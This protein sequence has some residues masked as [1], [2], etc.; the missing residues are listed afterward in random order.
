[1]TGELIEVPLPDC[2][3]D[4]SG[5]EVPAPLMDRGTYAVDP[6]PFGPPIVP[7][8]PELLRLHGFE[9]AS[10]PS[11]VGLPPGGIHISDGPRQTVVVNPEDTQGL[12]LTTNERRLQGCCN[13]DGGHGPNQLCG[14]CG[15][16]VA[17]LENDCWVGRTT[18]RFEPSAVHAIHG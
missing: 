15:L 4:D 17:T 14:N 1:L 18:L 2:E 13:L 7:A 11:W 9:Q 16:E 10:R 8:T 12:R 5:D 6:K 3:S